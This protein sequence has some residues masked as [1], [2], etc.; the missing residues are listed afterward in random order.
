MIDEHDKR[1]FKAI[2]SLL[3]KDDILVDVGANCGEYTSYFLSI[4]H[5]RCRIYSIE[6]SPE[7]CDELYVRFKN[8][9]NVTVMCYAISDVNGWIPFYK[10]QT[11]YTHNI[12][13]HGVD[14]VKHEKF[15]LVPSRRLDQLPIGQISLLKIDVEGAELSVLRG[16]HHIRPKRILLEAHFDTDWQDIYDLL[17][18]YNYRGIELSDGADVKRESRAYQSLW[19]LLEA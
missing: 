1:N 13:G 3:C 10:G 19:K 2:E 5:N 9:L 8:D 6:I 18:S 16:M 11:S 17:I 7:N 15:N 4:L 14:M 12:I